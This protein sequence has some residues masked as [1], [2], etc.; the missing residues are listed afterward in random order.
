LKKKAYDNFL[1]TKMSSTSYKLIYF[2][3]KGRAEVIRLLFALGGQEFEEE[4]IPMSATFAEWLERKPK[5][6]LQVAPQLE[7]TENGNTTILAQS[8]A[9][10][11]FLARKFNLYGSNE[12]EAARID[13]IVEQATDILLAFGKVYQAIFMGE[14]RKAE[15]V[16]VED[17]T[18]LNMLKL[19]QNLYDHNQKLNENSGFLVGKSL[20][21]ADIKLVHAYDWF[22][23][24]KANV[25]NSLPQLKEH[26][27]KIRSLPQLVDQYARSDKM[28]LT[29]YFSD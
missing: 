2:N 4:Q 29:V 9:I 6:L 27:E 28:R 11:R 23:S 12:I 19:I 8:A 21:Y 13:M 3:L 15:L 22:R 17:E 7:I 26:Y 24:K 14:D 16:K 18:A 1:R 20:T 25:L 5:M 10:E